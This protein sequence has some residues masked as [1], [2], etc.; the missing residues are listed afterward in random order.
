M[1]IISNWFFQNSLIAKINK[2]SPVFYIK[3]TDTIIA[4]KFIDSSRNGHVITAAAITTP[5]DSLILA[6]NDTTVIAALTAAGIYDTFYTDDDTPKTVLLSAIH[7]KTDY[8]FRNNKSILL[9]NELLEPNQNMLLRWLWPNFVISSNINL[10]IGITKTVAKFVNWVSGVIGSNVSYTAY[11]DY[12]PV[13][14]NT[15]YTVKRPGI[16]Y[17][18]DYAWYTSSFVF[19][20]GARISLTDYKYEI[21]SPA[22]AAFIRMDEMP[23]YG[24]LIYFR[25]STSIKWPTMGDSVTAQ[26]KW[27]PNVE[28]ELNINNLIYGEGFVALALAGTYISGVGATAM[29][30]DARI[31]IYPADSQLP[32][33]MGGTNDWYNNVPL[34]V[35]DSID[36]TTF[37]GALNVMIPKIKT[38]CPN[39][40]LI[41]LTPPYSECPGRAGFT[42]N[43]RLNQLGLSIKDYADCIIN[44]AIANNV[45]YIRL[46]DLWDH[47]N[48]ATYM[49]NETIFVHPSVAGGLLMA[50]NIKPKM[51]AIVQ[52]LM[53]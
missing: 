25:K 33:E 38:R 7:S 31:N 46:C 14:P 36:V 30:N 1:N 51:Y 37:N 28:I 52:N 43:G 23:A 15:A 44:R 32:S 35:I 49:S 9:F 19:I 4:G 20:S 16:N 22:N 18:F 12:I 26:S 27:Q 34:G 39:G 48:I 11:T 40:K 21:T 6:A 8:L 2:L 45:F 47:S 50:A 24:T 5:N 10:L 41:L 3:N 29:N 13:L 53:S 42:D 17:N